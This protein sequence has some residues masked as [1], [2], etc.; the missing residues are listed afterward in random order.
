MSWLRPLGA[1]GLTVSAIGLGTVKLGRDQGV[2][3][4]NSFTIPDD[5]AAGA[6]LAR[7]ALQEVD[8]RQAVFV[9]RSAAAVIATSF[10]NSETLSSY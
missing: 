4:P 1:T 6:L 5:R 9:K 2:R 8:G 10:D 7:A 3:Y